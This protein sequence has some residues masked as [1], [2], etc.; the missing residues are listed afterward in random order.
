MTRR[1]APA[2]PVT[3]AEPPPVPPV[4]S[5]P[6]LTGDLAATTAPTLV[7]DDAHVI[8][9]YRA[10]EPLERH[11]TGCCASATGSSLLGTGCRYA[12]DRERLLDVLRLAGVPDDRLPFRDR[13]ALERWLADRVRPS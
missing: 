5:P 1:A 6:P 9:V 12:R 4:T 10:L 7:L 11:V 2:P 8:A 3:G 13:A